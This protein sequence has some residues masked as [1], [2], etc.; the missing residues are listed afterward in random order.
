MVQA[1]INAFDNPALKEEAVIQ[2]LAGV[3]Y[4]ERGAVAEKFL[5]QRHESM[6]FSIMQNAIEYAWVV[7]NWLSAR[8]P[9]Q[10]MESLP[11]P[12][13]VCVRKFG[14]TRTDRNRGK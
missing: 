14:A 8:L 1:H 12:F 2:Y 13:D 9:F 11:I 3:P 5:G 6:N 4:N 10:N 7:I